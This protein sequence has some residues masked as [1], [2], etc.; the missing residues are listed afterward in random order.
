MSTK[1]QGSLLNT[2]PTQV[3]TGWPS[4]RQ[5]AISA[6]SATELQS[7]LLVFLAHVISSTL[8]MA[9]TH[10]SETLVYNKPTWHHTPEDGIKIRS[11][12]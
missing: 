4:H 5:V 12:R 2:D 3:T 10:S 8:N 1:G 6:F 9:A 7:V 11:S